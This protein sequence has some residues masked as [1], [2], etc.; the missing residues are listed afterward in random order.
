MAEK[1]ASASSDGQ[2]STVLMSHL[3]RLGNTVWFQPIPERGEIEVL[4]VTSD[5]KTYLVGMSN[6]AV[7][8]FVRTN[9]FI[10]F[11]GQSETYLVGLRGRP[12]PVK[13]LTSILGEKR[14]NNPDKGFLVVWEAY[15]G[16]PSLI[17]LFV[18]EVGSEVKVKVEE[19][20][21]TKNKVL[22]HSDGRLLVPLD[23]CWPEAKNAK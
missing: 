20:S 8:K 3:E 2:D 23:K 14:E 15:A 12:V 6:L 16:N 17:G 21:S 9:E 1:S 13:S 5:G 7:L 22:K 11:P 4:E 18:D 10:Q 19:F